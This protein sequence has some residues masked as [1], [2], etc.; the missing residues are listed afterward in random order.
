[1][2]PTIDDHFTITIPPAKV[3]VVHRFQSLLPD[4]V[5]R[6]IT[7][8]T[9]LLL[10]QLFLTDF[11]NIAERMGQHTV[12]E[13]STLRSLF[14]SQ[15]GQLQLMRLNPG[16]VGRRR[17]FFDGNGFEGRLGPYLVKLFAPELR[18]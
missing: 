18:V 10:F 4:N 1:M 17:L 11:A 2:A 13:I 7:L 14:N 5:A 15:R 6:L 8:V 16:N 12:R 3:I 9:V